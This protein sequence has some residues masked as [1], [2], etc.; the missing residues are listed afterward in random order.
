VVQQWVVLMVRQQQDQQLQL[1]K[2]T[3]RNHLQCWLTR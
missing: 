1:Q 2:E 3:G